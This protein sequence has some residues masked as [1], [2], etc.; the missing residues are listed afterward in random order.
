MT[1]NYNSN[2]SQKMTEDQQQVQVK[3]NVS[4]VVSYYNMI[5]SMI[6]NQCAILLGYLQNFKKATPLLNEYQRVWNKY[7]QSIIEINRY[8][9]PFAELVNDLYKKRFPELPRFPEFSIWRMMTKAWIQKVYNPLAPVL[10][11]AFRCLT[12]K[13]RMQRNSTF[14]EMLEKSGF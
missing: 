9:S 4:D 1:P 13:L 14:N 5:A 10:R 7:V 12:L 2:N 11:N 3:E 6:N 8:F